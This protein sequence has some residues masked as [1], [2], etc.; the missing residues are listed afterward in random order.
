M[1]LVPEAIIQEAPINSL[2]SA[3]KLRNLDTDTNR[4]V[5]TKLI[6]K[7]PERCW[8]RRFGIIIC[9]NTSVYDQRGRPFFPKSE[10][11]LHLAILLGLA[12]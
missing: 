1:L 11:V 5:P 6:C 10:A 9:R 2:F 7:R 12:L 4:P 3:Y 8:L